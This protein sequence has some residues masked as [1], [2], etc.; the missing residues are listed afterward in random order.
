M[1]RS[2]CFVTL[3]V[4]SPAWMPVAVSQPGPA[5]EGPGTTSPD[6]GGS[7]SKDDREF[8]RESGRDGHAEVKLGRIAEKNALD[9]E[10]KKFAERMMKEHIAA[11]A[12]LKSLAGRK[13]ETLPTDIGRHEQKL[14]RLSMETGK[15]FDRNFMRAM[16]KDH[17]KTVKDL[18]RAAREC[19]DADLRAWAAKTLKVARQQESD[20]KEI[21]QRMGGGGK[22]A[23]DEGD[24]PGPPPQRPD[25]PPPGG[26]PDGPPPPNP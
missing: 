3:L 16:V 12:E 2:F 7:L 25:G 20:A 5:P 26:R 21:S 23:E 13:G 1:I 22:T 17:E 8:L 19:N 14:S 18:T 4:C 10:V 15:D 11:N 24:Q 9:S 6:A